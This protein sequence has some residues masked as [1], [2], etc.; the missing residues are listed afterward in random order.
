MS[1]IITLIFKHLSKITIIEYLFIC[2]GTNG[3][4]GPWFGYLTELCSSRIYGNRKHESAKTVKNNLW[5]EPSD[6]RA[7]RNLFLLLYLLYCAA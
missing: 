3:C 6:I 7:L 1:L 5:Y 4:P 2:A